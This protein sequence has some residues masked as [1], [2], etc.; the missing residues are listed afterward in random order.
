MPPPSNR[1]EFEHNIYMTIESAL[2]KI[3]NKHFDPGFVHWTLP[4]LQRLKY[5]PNNRI[6][7]NS[8]DEQLRLES[9]M[10]QLLPPPIIKQEDIGY[11]T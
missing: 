5:T 9:N 10:M 1:S 11:N 2:R 3:E 7:F 6:D 8:V 4:R